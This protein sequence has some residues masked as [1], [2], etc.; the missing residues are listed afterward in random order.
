MTKDVLSIL[1]DCGQDVGGATIT[2]IPGG[3]SCETALVSLNSGDFV[4]KRAL[5]RLKVSEVWM[6]A[7]SRITAEAAGLEW[8]HQLTPHNVPAPLGVSKKHFGLVLPHAPRP[9]PDLRTILL[10]DP[11]RAPE[12]VGKKLGDIAVTWHSHSPELAKGGE[13]DDR[14]RLTELRLDPFYRDIATRWPHFEGVIGALVEE[15]YQA[16][17]CVVHGDF[18]PKNILCLPT[19]DIWVIDTEVAHIGQPVLDSASM[20]AHLTIKAFHHRGKASFAAIEKI[21]RDFIDTISGHSPSVPRS[22]PG[23]MGVVMAVRVA[24]RAQVPYLSDENKAAV[25]RAAT[26]LLDGAPIESLEVA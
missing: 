13:L 18:T 19:G 14:V 15:L 12:N 20:L 25:A 4:V 26:M 21:R 7:P 9:C 11:S 5:A 6:S 23:H 3:V 2:P 1:Q 8:F 10:D 16:Q 17:V 22:L 24:G